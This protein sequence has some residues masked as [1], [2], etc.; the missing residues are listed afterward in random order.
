MTE[1]LPSLDRETWQPKTGL[2][3]QVKQGE[4]TTVEQLLETGRPI[5][6]AE[7]V[8]VLIPELNSETLQV[9]STQRVTDSGKRTQFRV[10][11]VIGD[12]KGHVGVGVG[13][14]EEMRPALERAIRDAKKHIISVP[15][16]CG[17]WECKCHVS[18]S[19]PRKVTGKEG[20][21]V[22]VIKP[23]PRG[24]GLASHDVVKKVLQMAGVKDVWSFS[25]GGANTYNVAQAAIQALQSLNTLKPVAEK[26][27]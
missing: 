13:K 5:L 4:I 27:A 21:S 14:K 1:K 16:G 10:V 8:D 20:S 15:T 3:Q 25:A 9:K 22:V 24:L 12:R 11:V 17:S 19:I 18:H 6:E 26:S 2:G 7:I 23:A